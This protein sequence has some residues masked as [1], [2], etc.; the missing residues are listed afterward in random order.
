MRDEGNDQVAELLRE[1]RDGQRLALERQTEALALQR[2]QMDLVRQQAE[3]NE[4]IQG[5]AE[6]LQER[7]ATMMRTA[8]RATVVL[9]AIVAALVLYLGWILIR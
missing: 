5:R 6:A 1:I 9:V 2:A 3:R 4:R 8:R 7:G